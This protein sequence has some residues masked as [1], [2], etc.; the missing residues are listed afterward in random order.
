MIELHEND[1]IM[2]RSQECQCE[3][4]I[5]KTLIVETTEHVLLSKYDSYMKTMHVLAQILKWRKIVSKTKDGNLT[6]DDCK[7]AENFLIR[8][9]QKR[10]FDEFE[11][12]INTDSVNSKSSI[13]SLDPVLNKEVNL[14]TVGGRLNYSDLP[15]EAKH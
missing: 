3:A 12:L 7:I 6:C 9:V 1:Q 10:Q 14:I 5:Q 8:S 4:K 11:K 13:A 15:E 2:D